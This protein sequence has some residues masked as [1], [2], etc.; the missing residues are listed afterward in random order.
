VTPL[1]VLVWALAILGV[2]I[3]GVVVAVVV[4][5]VIVGIV[6]AFSAARV[7]RVIS[8]TRVRK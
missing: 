5:L 1:D 8:V 4:L 7:R 2:V 6:S 3:L